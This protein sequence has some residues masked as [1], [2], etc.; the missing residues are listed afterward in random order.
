M[1]EKDEIL[2]EEYKNGNSH[3]FGILFQQNKMFVLGICA[4]YSND[5][6][7]AADYC[8]EIFEKLMQDLKKHDVQN[9]RPWLYV[10]AKNYCL[11]KFRKAPEQKKL[12]GFMENTLSFHPY[13]EEEKE[14]LFLCLEKNI[15]LL[16]EEQKKCIKLFYLEGKSY[17]EISNILNI[18]LNKVK[19][20]IQN[21]KRNL[22]IKMKQE[23]DN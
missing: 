9:F 12:D 3:S 20:N 13:I 15:E 1:Q 4:K 7:L 16:N 11:G 22:L 6:D 17:Q 10:Y 18:D 8:M 21:G 5:P 19:S 2:I 14:E 23:N